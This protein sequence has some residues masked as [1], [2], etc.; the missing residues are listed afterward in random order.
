MQVSL[1]L[2]S[3]LKTV[4]TR[5]LHCTWL[6]NYEGTING[7]RTHPKNYTY[8]PKKCNEQYFGCSHTLVCIKS[9]IFLNK[10]KLSTFKIRLPARAMRVVLPRSG[11]QRRPR[12]AAPFVATL[13]QTPLPRLACKIIHLHTRRPSRLP[14]PNRTEHGHPLASVLANSFLPFIHILLGFTLVNTG[15]FWVG[16]FKTILNYSVFIYLATL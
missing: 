6:E 2:P 1:R 3:P 15:Y 13:P 4:I 5:K 10:I 14:Y 9:Y 8:K 11:L 16:I 12:A 7:N